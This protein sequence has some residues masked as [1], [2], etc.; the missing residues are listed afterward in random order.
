M[1]EIKIADAT[2]HNK[3]RRIEN[4]IHVFRSDLRK[5]FKSFHFYAEY[6]RDVSKVPLSILNIPALSSVIHFAWA[7]GCDVQIGELDSVHLRGL[8]KARETFN[9]EKEFEYMSL[10]GEV[11]PRKSVE[12]CFGRKGREALLF[13]GGIDSTASRI[14]RNPSS[15]IMIWG[16]DVPTEWN[17]FWNR[18]M[19]EYGYLNPSIVKTNSEEIYNK[20]R[21]IL[22]GN[23]LKAGYRAGYSYSINTLG[24]CAPITV[25]NV[26]VLMMASDFPLKYYGDPD[27]PFQNWKPHFM[28]NQWLGWADIKT[29]N[30]EDQYNRPEKIERIIKPHFDVYG[31]SQL[32]VCGNL[33]FLK[34]RENKLNLNCSH[35]DKC[36]RAIANLSLNDINPTECG[37]T[38][39]DETFKTIKKDLLEGKWNKWRTRYFWGEIKK[40]IP[41]KIRNDFNGSRK[42]LEWLRGYDL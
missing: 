38:V 10:K 18:V 6:D 33:K 2:L 42:F 31:Y 25:D 8:E 9:R 11:N 22:L 21:L 12:N 15:L 20:G 30:V 34:A 37:F 24:V 14:L 16:F 13:S 35:C 32:R 36:E 29:F 3:G 26:D 7:V 23:K 41:K 5:Y 27:Y 4:Y 28:V 1:D 17:G 40:H 19:G 39:T